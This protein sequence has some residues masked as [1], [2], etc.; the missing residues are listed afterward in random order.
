MLCIGGLT[1]WNVTETHSVKSANID[2]KRGLLISFKH[3]DG[4]QSIFFPTYAVEKM[5]SSIVEEKLD[6]TSHPD[7]NDVIELSVTQPSAE[8]LAQLEGTPVVLGNGEVA[9]VRCGDDR[10][11]MLAFEVELDDLFDSDV[12]IYVPL[13]EV[14]RFLLQ[15]TQQYW[16]LQSISG[17][18]I[19]GHGVDYMNERG[20]GEWI[21]APD[22][23]FD[24]E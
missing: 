9:M 2:G 19:L 3:D 1:I 13:T 7:G 5:L 4:D 6:A 16:A 15:V 14:D 23:P 22:D 18:D 11:L 20:G 10:G 21:E 8:C 24:D 17:K 12:L